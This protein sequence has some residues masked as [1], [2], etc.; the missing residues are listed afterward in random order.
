MSRA[1]FIFGLGYSASMLAH[2]LMAQGWT[3]AGTV[4][5][6]GKAQALTD[7]G[8]AALVHDKGKSEAIADRLKRA[9]HILSS[10]PPDEEGDPVLRAFAP[11]IAGQADRL[12]WLGYLSTVGVYGDRQG[13]MV[14]EGSDLRPANERSRR[15]VEAE[16]QWT[17]LARRMGAAL[18]IF[19]IAGI[20]GPGRNPL[21]AML[22][23]TARRIVK[24]GQV[25][26]RIHVADIATAIAA[27]MARPPDGVRA[28]NLAD[29]M[30]SPADE[31][32]AHAAGLLG[33]EPPPEIPL[34]QAGLS[35][36]GLSFYGE[37]KRVLNRRIKQE[38]GVVLAYPSYR[39]GLAALHAAM[40]PA[41]QSSDSVN[42]SS[43]A[44]SS[45]RDSR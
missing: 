39:E 6:P 12:S 30:P 3:V 10:V 36:M 21:E 9:S 8:I 40:A 15:R 11:L 29:D 4:R 41:G 22:A 31:V 18:A 13:G 2:R 1:L 25:F 23:G 28:Y 26:N 42:A 5:S 17:A 38:L 34:A 16:R 32:V 14:D 19:R 43:L 24:P 20:Y 44:I 27:S 37:S 33:L 35:P 45:S 7:A